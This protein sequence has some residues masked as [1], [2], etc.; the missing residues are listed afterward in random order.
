[1]E[2]LNLQAVMATPGV[3]GSATTSN[4]TMEVEKYLGIEAARQVDCRVVLNFARVVFVDFFEILIVSEEEKWGQRKQ[5]LIQNCVQIFESVG[6]A[7]SMIIINYSYFL[8][9]KSVPLLEFSPWTRHPNTDTL[10]YYYARLVKY[11]AT[12][13]C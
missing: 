4:H 12:L 9:T 5:V 7:Y 13:V 11:Y 8:Y 3:K 2:G 10:V 6:I 1:M